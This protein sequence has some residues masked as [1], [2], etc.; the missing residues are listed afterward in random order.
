MAT[1]VSNAQY[2]APE[3]ANS[4]LRNHRQ[5]IHQAHGDT[6]P[7]VKTEASASPDLPPAS[8]STTASNTSLQQ[9]QFQFH[10]QPPPA[11]R[12]SSHSSRNPSEPPISTNLG[13]IVQP[14][15]PSIYRF[16]ADASTAQYKLMSN[17]NTPNSQS[18]SSASDTSNGHNPAN[19]G[20]N[21][22]D[23]AS[24]QHTMSFADE[25]DEVSELMDVGASGLAMLSGPGVNV[26]QGGSSSEKTIRRRSSKG[27]VLA[28]PLSSRRGTQSQ[29][30]VSN[31]RGYVS[32][33]AAGYSTQWRYPVRSLC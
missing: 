13:F 6:N 33:L 23:L 1:F 17:N 32:P 8:P 3:H 21:K 2:F 30:V 29:Q 9:F 10:S 15:P 26:G 22:F 14:P 5:Q 20:N 12:S 24:I 27:E 25:Y 19:Q 31:D 28:S 4:T 7:P 16:G 18:W 11:F